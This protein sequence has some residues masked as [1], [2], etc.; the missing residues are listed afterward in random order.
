MRLEHYRESLAML[1]QIAAR[2][3]LTQR[4]ANYRTLVAGAPGAGPT[5]AVLSRGG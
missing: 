4:L 2:H 5:P 3:P 1:Q